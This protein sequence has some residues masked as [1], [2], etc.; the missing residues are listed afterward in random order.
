MSVASP[1]EL[2]PLYFGLD[3]LF[4]IHVKLFVQDVY[5]LRTHSQIPEVY[6][7]SNHP[8]RKVAIT[9]LVVEKD[10]KTKYVKYVVDDGTGYISCISWFSDEEQKLSQRET[11]DLGSLVTVYG[12]ISV[13]R[14]VRQISVNGIEKDPN[15][16]PYRWLEILQL[17]KTVY[18]IPFELTEELKAEAE[19]VVTASLADAQ[20]REE[21]SNYAENLEKLR[22]D[23]EERTPTEADVKEFAKLMILTN[24]WINIP[25]RLLR[26]DDTILALVDRILRAVDPT[27]EPTLQK[28][29]NLLTRVVTSL[30]K[31]C[32][33]FLHD[34]DE[35]V[36]QV[37]RYD[38]NLRGAILDLLPTDSQ[39][40]PELQDDYAYGL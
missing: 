39:S 1:E 4:W 26:Y 40:N 5:Q 35:D 8:I 3:T 16:E 31:E 21:D 6:L 22:L 32:F 10:E 20:A 14:D 23:L 9:G 27:I 7:Y 17:K 28:V 33:M 18:D 29:N 13:F 38:V 30:V 12:R 19:Q 37:V 34:E 24:D 2:E 25:Y 36:Y 15:V 11:I